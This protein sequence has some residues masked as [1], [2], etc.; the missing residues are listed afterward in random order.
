MNVYEDLSIEDPSK[1][2]QLFLDYT[3]M[4]EFLEDPLIISK[5]DGVRY[6]D[7][8]GKMYY[9]GIAG[10]FT[11]SVGHNNTRILNAIKKQLDILTFS[12]PLHS[13]NPPAIHLANRISELLPGDLKTVKLVSGGSEATESALKMAR[14]YFHNT[15]QSKKF[16]TI[17]MY[18]GY[19]GA[20]FGAMSATG[21]GP[22]KTKWTYEPLL[23]GFIHVFPP[24]CYR[25]PYEKEYPSCGVFCARI[26]REIIE[27]ETPRTV[28]SI[29]VEPI[30]NT[31]GVLVPPKEFL[32]ILRKICTDL[33]V[34][35]IYDE[36]ITGW[37][38]TGN[39]FAAQTFNAIPDILCM[40]KGMA[41]GYASLAAIAFS[42]QL[43]RAFLGSSD[44]GIEFGHGHTYAGNP[45]AS[46]A[47]LAVINEIL[48]NNL[49]ENV[50]V[51]GQ[52]LKEK[53]R[54]F[55]SYG[56]VGDVRGCGLYVGVELVK[57]P[58]TKLPFS[59]NE[60]I[61]KKIGRK[62]LKNGLII[63]YSPDWFSMAPSLNVTREEIDTMM[64]ILRNSVEEVLKE[65]NIQ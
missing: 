9:D 53:L 50:K 28:A 33:D 11:V 64:D 58:D 19:H 54:E 60:K 34:I 30:N 47:G 7:I 51:M 23:G 55:T 5:A 61:G 27:K 16:K 43:K 26:I 42:N 40:G 59:E 32:P 39:L 13:T 12:P 45:V 57:N 25:C 63:R 24:Y 56:I 4:K 22:S 2:E 18:Y 62:A 46:A 52:Y 6:W 17:S 8:H 48:E 44:A 3:Q 29:I 38:R 10:I 35:L 41:S 31:G 65:D 14:Q 20:T 1:L 36:I 37:G 49:L 15:G 21:G